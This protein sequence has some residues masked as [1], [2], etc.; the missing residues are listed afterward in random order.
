MIIRLTFS[1]GS[2]TLCLAL[3][4]TASEMCLL[5]THHRHEH[6]RMATA[7]NL[8][9]AVL[10]QQDEERNLVACGWSLSGVQTPPA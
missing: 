4:R 1:R 5:M 7:P 6:L 3:I 10:R 8:I 9:E 2:E